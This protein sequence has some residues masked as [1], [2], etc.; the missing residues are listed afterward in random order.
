MRVLV[1][2]DDPTIT[3]VMSAQLQLFD[4]EV[5]EATSGRQALSLVREWRPD[6]VV[7]DLMM[8]PVDGFEVA[9]SISTDQ[10]LD[11]VRLVAM[12]GYDSPERRMVAAQ[13]GY[14]AF[15]SKPVSAQT[16]HNAVTGHEER[17]WHL[18]D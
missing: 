14:D 6:V 7:C 11:G 13:S 5:R 9:L 8:E 10:N 15:L 17:G 18:P 1:V 3:L 12:S 16:L 2:D 4:H